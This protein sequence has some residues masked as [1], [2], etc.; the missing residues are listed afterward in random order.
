MGSG[1]TGSRRLGLWPRQDLES[2]RR[3]RQVRSNLDAP[4]RLA[5]L[6]TTPCANTGAYDL[7]DRPAAKGIYPL[8]PFPSPPSAGSPVRSPTAPRRPAVPPSS[9]VGSRRCLHKQPWLSRLVLRA[10]RAAP[11]T[12]V[13][14]FENWAKR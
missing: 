3:S 9:S 10:A 12:V 6:S 8:H 7:Q 5:W 4:G 1:L 14:H 2:V 13:T 11:A